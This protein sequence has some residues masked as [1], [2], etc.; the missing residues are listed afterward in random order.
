MKKFVVLLVVLCAA[1]SVMAQDVVSDFQKKYGNGEEF[2][3][4]NISAKMFQM[5][6]SVAEPETEE[7]VKNLTG[8]KVLTAEKDM[9]K[10]YQDAVAF[11][12]RSGSGYEELMSVQEKDEDVRMFTKESKGVIT[13]LIIIVG[14]K[15]DFVLM[16]ITGKIDLKQMAKLSKSMNINGMEYLNRVK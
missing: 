13:E 8:M 5:M 11:V 1:M 3:N 14:G 10:Y 7:I 9:A 16:G 4:I 12:N 2:T 15:K 6:A